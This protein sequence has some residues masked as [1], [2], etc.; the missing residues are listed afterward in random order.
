MNLTGPKLVKNTN[1]KKQH[2]FSEKCLLTCTLQTDSE[3]TSYKLNVVYIY[4]FN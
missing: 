3:K 1:I 4:M 2:D